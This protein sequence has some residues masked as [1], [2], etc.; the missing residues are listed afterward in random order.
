MSSSADRIVNETRALLTEQGAAVSMADVARAAGVS[1]QAVYLHFPSRGQLFMA[2]VRQMDDEAD[3][4]ARCTHALS[5]PDPTEAL[6]AFIAT[7]LGFVATIRPVATMLLA[8]RNTDHDAWAA[9]EDRMGELRSGYQ[10][11]TRRLAAAGRLRSG[12]HARGAADLAWALTSVPVWEQLVVDRGWTAARADRHLIDAVM[13]A[14][15]E[16]V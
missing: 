8:A 3:I 14:L 7:W 16:P 12:L 13:A 15:T 1:R 9:W 10:H 6:R 5:T 4:R 11:A 2:V